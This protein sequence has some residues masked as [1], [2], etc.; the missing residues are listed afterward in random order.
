MKDLK[1]RFVGDGY[2]NKTSTDLA[3]RMADEMFKQTSKI[4]KTPKI[5]V[6]VTDGISSYSMSYLQQPIKSLKGSQVTIMSV[7]VGLKRPPGIW[8]LEAEK[9]LK[10]MASNDDLYFQIGTFD[11]L[12]DEIKNMQKFICSGM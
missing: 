3:L 6:I 11:K 9:E 8:P 4:R 2:P 10:F 1:T 12:E 5:L 7:G